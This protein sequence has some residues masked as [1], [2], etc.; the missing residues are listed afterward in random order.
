MT[1]FKEKSRVLLPS[2]AFGSNANVSEILAQSS[3]IFILGYSFT[4]L[5]G[6]F[7]DSLSKAVSNGA[8]IKIMIIYPNKQAIK[9]I[10]AEAL[11]SKLKRVVH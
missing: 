1:G 4:G 2:E 9:V 5:L 3:T 7:N 8:N 10:E 6:T 11:K